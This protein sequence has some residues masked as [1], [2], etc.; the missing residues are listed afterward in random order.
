VT[1]LRLGD[2]W[3]VTLIGY[4]GQHVPA[5]EQGFLAYTRSLRTRDVYDVVKHAEP[6]TDPVM[7]R[8]PAS[9]RRR[10][11][12]LGR[13]PQEFLVIGDALCSFNPVYAQGMSVAAL[14][15]LAL[16]ECLAVGPDHLARRFYQRTGAIVDSAWSVSAGGDL[17]FPEVQGERTPMVRFIN[18]YLNKLHVAA[19]AD[20]VV[21]AAFQ[22]VVNMLAP[23]P[24]V[25][26]PRIA[27]RVLWGNVRVASSAAF[28]EKTPDPVLSQG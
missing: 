18:W 12:K 16:G 24:S 3:H 7:Y 27:L 2:R 10:Y 19:H 17:R 21:A 14:E 4:L 9:Q 5:E 15:A 25:L 28:T 23:A 6:L 13:C 1:W 8:F 22:R 11:D 20:P 26:L